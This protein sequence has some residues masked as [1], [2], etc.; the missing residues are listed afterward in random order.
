MSSK[1]NTMKSFLFSC[2][3]LAATFCVNAQEWVDL[4]Q[5]PDANLYQIQDKF[6]K[7][8]QDKDK[9]EKGKGYKAFKRWENF[10]EPRVYPS[11]NI[12]LLNLT[13]K[14]YE[15]WYK[16][17]SANQNNTAGKLISSSP[18]QLASTTWTAIG[19]MGPMSG[20]AGGQFLKSGRINFITV[21]P[22][23][24][25]TLFIGAPAGGLW[26]ST[27]GGTTWTT[28][29][30]NLTVTGCSDL[31][32]DPLNPNNM[33]LAMG[34][35][36]AG[37]TRS[38]GV[39]KSTDGGNT[40]ATT[41]LTNPVTNNF[42]IRRL[43]INPVNPQIVLAATNGGIY[44]T[45]NGGTN[46]TQ[47][48]TSNCYDLEFKPGDPNTVYAAGSSF[49]ISTNGGASFTQ[50]TNG[51]PT[52]GVGRMA[53]AVTPADPAYVYVLA[54][55]SSSSGFLGFY[56]STASGTVFATMPTTLNL[57]GWSS[58][59]SDTGGQG[60]YDLCIACSP[61]NKDEVVTGGV[62]VWRT[63][64]GGS[65]WAIY[66]HWTGS[67]APF[68][69]ADHHDLEY[70]PDGTLFNTNDGTVYKRTGT[71]WTEI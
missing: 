29:T 18:Q 67:G 46:W 37:D 21:H 7:Y 48:S 45:I 9:S 58:T 5:K 57:L 35:G 20:S 70:A 52:T 11:G 59:G 4:M 17:Y 27:N 30:D 65:S 61:L 68:T 64:N 69:H 23:N 15:E 54:S 60:W 51:I 8:W 26:K 42:L 13:G 14:N 6:E 40:W 22:T 34:D 39:L 24:T 2:S 28:N 41:G 50:V 33:F 43:I 19:P 32:I 36:D 71:T 44:R 38:I 66:G 12:S 1:K 63:T 25:L 3:L 49:R 56:R 55:S 10:A 16:N 31:A 62:N 47:V 53:I